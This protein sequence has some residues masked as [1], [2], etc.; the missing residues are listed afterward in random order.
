MPSSTNPLRSLLTALLAAAVLAACQTPP[1]PPAAPTNQQTRVDKLTQLG[2]VPQPDGWELSL[3]VKLLFDTDIDTLT[4]QGSASLRAMART[5][6]EV[7]IDR[8]R[9]EG[10]T[11][12]VG[13]ARYNHKLSLRRAESVAAQ[14]VQAGLDPQSIQ[15]VGL[16]F[17]KPVADNGTPDGRAQ[18]RRVVITVRAD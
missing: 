16:G 6:H 2:F 14:L 7:G 13:D 12:N 3:G 15:R 17:G 5:L 8:V 10:H 4:P 9:V 1:A 18:N 11:D